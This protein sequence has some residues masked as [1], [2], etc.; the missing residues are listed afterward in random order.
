MD[1]ACSVQ[2]VAYVLSISQSKPGMR[3]GGAGRVALLLLSAVG[4]ATGGFYAV[5][6]TKNQF[7]TVNTHV[8]AYSC[9][10]MCVN[11]S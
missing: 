8:C 9:I 11:V 7:D 1:G 2:A 6:Q 5:K 10:C 3:P 4:V